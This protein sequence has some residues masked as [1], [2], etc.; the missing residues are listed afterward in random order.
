M[1]S[2][3]CWRNSVESAK[4]KLQKLSKELEKLR[5]NIETEECLGFFKTI[6]FNNYGEQYAERHLMVIFSI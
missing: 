2:N 4:G 6:L 3:L 5:K 1:N